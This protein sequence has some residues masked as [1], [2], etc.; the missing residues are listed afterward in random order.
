MLGRGLRGART[1][2]HGRSDRTRGCAQRDPPPSVRGLAHRGAGSVR[3]KQSRAGPPTLTPPRPRFGPLPIPQPRSRPRPRSPARA[4]LERGVGGAAARPPPQT[5]VPGSLGER[6]PRSG[7]SDCPGASARTGAG[8][9]PR[10]Q[11]SPWQP[12][13]PLAA[14]AQRGPAGAA[15]LAPPRRRQ[16]FHWAGGQAASTDWTG[17]GRH[18]LAIGRSG[19]PSLPTTAPRGVAEARAPAGT[20]AAEARARAAPSGG[21]PPPGCL[22]GRPRTVR[23]ERGREQAGRP[24]AGLGPGRS[25]TTPSSQVSCSSACCWPGAGRHALPSASVVCIPH[26]PRGSVLLPSHFTDGKLRLREVLTSFRSPG[27][28]PSPSDSGARALSHPHCPR[29]P[30]VEAGV[31]G[32]GSFSRVERNP[33]VN[34]GFPPRS[35]ITRQTPWAQPILQGPRDW[36]PSRSSPKG[37]RSGPGEEKFVCA[38]S[39]LSG[40]HFLHPTWGHAGSLWGSVTRVGFSTGY[41]SLPGGEQPPGPCS[42]TGHTHDHKWDH[43]P[44]PAPGNFG[45]QGAPV[46]M[47]PS[48]ACFRGSLSSDPGSC[49]VLSRSCS[50]CTW[51]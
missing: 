34:S 9:T 46:W 45:V 14:R 4:Y 41:I 40:V 11:R 2:A 5:G 28:Q 13:A 8:L 50:G 31:G 10:G 49:V 48:G 27:L 21:S 33:S 22:G 42:D 39:P 32:A 18:R 47:L 6:R 19:C 43:N 3:V 35:G 17:V 7:A 26:N 44:R 30:T 1:E 15:T 12:S 16:C 24:I 36:P 25:I 29:V 37:H 20:S 38:F 51:R 23:P